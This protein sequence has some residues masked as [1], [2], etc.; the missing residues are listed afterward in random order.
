MSRFSWL[1]LIAVFAGCNY[2]TQCERYIV[3]SGFWGRFV[4]YYGKKGSKQE[5]DKEG[6]VV[7]NIS[8][9][10]QCFTPAS[11]E[12]GVGNPDQ[13]FRYFERLAPDSLREIFL[14]RESRYLKDTANN[15]YNKYVFY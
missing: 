3:P 13:T 12:T 7:Y 9:K 2:T 15:K 6:C 4:I 1:L 8:A 10:G 14:F 11:Y 5:H